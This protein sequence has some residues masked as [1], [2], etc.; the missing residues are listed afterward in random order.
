[1]CIHNYRLKLILKLKIM[2]NLFNFLMI[3][4]LIIP[5]NSCSSDD[6]NDV[7]TVLTFLEKHDGSVWFL[8]NNDDY[9]D[10]YFRLINNVITPI[11]SWEMDIYENDDCYYYERLNITVIGYEITENLEN[12]F[13]ITFLNPEDE[14]NVYTVTLT[15]SDN[16]LEMKYTRFENGIE[17]STF[18]DYYSSS[19]ID[20]DGL[21]I[22]D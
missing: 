7:N 4:T 6:G 11:E 8:Q 21:I 14:T 16:I 17:I 18:T 19:S 15:V 22:C 5:F 20:L 2:R 3:A 10:Y 12:K 9:Y 13:E 1:M